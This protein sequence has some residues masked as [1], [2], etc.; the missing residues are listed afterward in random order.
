VI[1]NLAPT[2]EQVKVLVA[3]DSAVY[4]TLI[5]Q[6]LWGERYSLV[7]AD[8]GHQAIK[9]F[10]CHRPAVVIVDWVMPDLTGIEICQ[11]IRSKSQA[12]YTYMI[13][14]TGMIEK[15]NVVAGLAAGAD[16]YLTKPFHDRELI[17]RVGVGIRIIE[18]QRQ[19]EANNILLQQLALTDALTGLPNRRAIDE[20]A[21]R[22]VL[23]AARHK[24]SFWVA[25]ADLDHFKNVNDTHGHEAGD[26]VLKKF[27]G[28]L[29]AHSRRSDICGR[30]GGE[31]FLLAF[32]HASKANAWMVV[33]RVRK[34]FEATEF[35]FRGRPLRVTASFGLAGFEGPRAPDFGDLI[36]QADRALY[37]AKRLGR[38]RIEMATAAEEV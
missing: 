21:V 30:L 15:E 5:E 31:E 14:L 19:I 7:F 20:W 12:S 4:R 22:Q 25:M 17:A 18:L 16:D 36:A 29:K 6:T 9:L 34:E 33:E 1:R 23:A 2:A 24:F 38:N 10:E 37:S 28:I 27:S 3:D 35:V 32:T 11:H 26:Q 8:S 13:I